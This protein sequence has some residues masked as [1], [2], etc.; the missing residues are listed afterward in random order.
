[1]LNCV[2]TIDSAEDVIVTMSVTCV[3]DGASVHGREKVIS[4]RSA[5]VVIATASDSDPVDI[6]SKISEAA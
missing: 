5:A 1:V 4:S 6:P 3:R 2:V